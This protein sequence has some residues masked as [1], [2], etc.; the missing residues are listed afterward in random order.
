MTKPAGQ[1]GLVIYGFGGAG[2]PP[3]AGSAIWKLWFM[4]FPT[5]F[6]FA[7]IRMPFRCQRI[8]YCNLRLSA[9]MAM[10]SLFVGLPRLFWMV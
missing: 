10:N 4:L 5:T 2:K 8:L 9:I 6:R 3:R 7:D 1:C